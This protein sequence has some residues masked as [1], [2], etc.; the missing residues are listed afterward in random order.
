MA[1][2]SNCKYLATEDKPCQ[3]CKKYDLWNEKAE[4]KGCEMKTISNADLEEMR[5]FR[6]E[7]CSLLELSRGYEIGIQNVK[8]LLC[9]TTKAKN[10]DK[11]V[12]IQDKLK[13]YKT[14]WNMFGIG[15]NILIL[16]TENNRTRRAK[17]R[18]KTATNI[19]IDH[20]SIMFS[21]LVDG[22]RKIKKL[23]EELN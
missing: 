11:E 23:E 22:T 12:I 21:Q 10:G 2:C 3:N 17:I 9:I 15:D 16:D 8:K 4:K 20:E 19:I 5:L 13:K 6:G 1:N 18:N 7:G 14:Y